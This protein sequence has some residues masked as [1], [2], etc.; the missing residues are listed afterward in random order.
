MPTLTPGE[1]K[2]LEMATLRK[3][4]EH[5]DVD[6]IRAAMDN[7][8]VEIYD[9][10][11]LFLTDSKID[12]NKMIE[13]RVDSYQDQLSGLLRSVFGSGPVDRLARSKD[14]HCPSVSGIKRCDITM[15]II[16]CAV[17]NRAL[18]PLPQGEVRDGVLREMNKILQA[19]SLVSQDRVMEM[20]IH[21]YLEKH[22]KPLAQRFA[23]VFAHDLFHLLLHFLPGELKEDSSQQ[24]SDIRN[25]PTDTSTGQTP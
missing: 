15:A 23:Q 6:V 1:S 19:Q 4:G 16:E 5:T 7:I 20:A 17:T 24:P 22:V 10:T 11:K 25:I 9:A 18:R 21:Q 8:Q 2:L 13:L 14:V 3:G 12:G